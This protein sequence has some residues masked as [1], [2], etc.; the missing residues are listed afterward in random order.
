MPL[1]GLL[2]AILIGYF[3]PKEDVRSILSNNGKLNNNLVI[4]IFLVLVRYIT[5]ILIMLVFLSAIHIIG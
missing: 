2:V 3:V 1:G 4:S 5:P